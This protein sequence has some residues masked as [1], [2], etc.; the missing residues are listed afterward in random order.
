MSD[1]GIPGGSSSFGNITNDPGQ[2]SRMAKSL[3]GGRKA[4]R[5]GAGV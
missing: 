1:T 2:V 5:E 4:N 3:K